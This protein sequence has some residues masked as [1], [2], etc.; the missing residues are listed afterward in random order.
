[1]R[2]HGRSVVLLAAALAAGCPST[3]VYRT[4]EPVAP[5]RWRLGGAAGVAALRDT[6]QDTR[7]PTGHLELGARRGVAPGVDVGAK[8]F[9]FGVGADATIRLRGGRWALALAPEVT[10]LYTGES[11]AVPEALHLFAGTALV[12]TRALSPRWSLSLGPLAGWGLYRPTS[13]GAAQGLWLGAFVN[14]AVRV[15]GCWQLV[16]ELG[17][18]GVVSGDVPVRGGAVRF[19]VGLARD[20]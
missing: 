2:I 1:M 13:G 4:A 17:V 14:A 20:L 19:G 9:T 5:G 15:W 7:I 8:L 16:P 10:G 3:T 6:E 11:G 12:A 18:L